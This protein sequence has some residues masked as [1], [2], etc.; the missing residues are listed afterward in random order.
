MPRLPGSWRQ[1]MFLRRRRTDR[2]AGRDRTHIPA[3]LTA[4]SRQKLD[5]PADWLCIPAIQKLRVRYLI[6]CCVN[7]KKPLELPYRNL[8]CLRRITQPHTKQ[9]DG[10]VVNDNN[11]KIVN[12]TICDFRESNKEPTKHKVVI[13]LPPTQ[14]EENS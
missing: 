9:F 6:I 10:L 12:Q 11:D 13:L 8:F 4:D 1:S 7:I 2:P 3:G 5:L 14:E